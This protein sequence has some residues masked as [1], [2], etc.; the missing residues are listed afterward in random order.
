MLEE[1]IKR[2]IARV[3]RVRPEFQESVSWYLPHDNALAHY[4]GIISKF[5]AKQGIPVLSHP[6]YSPDLALADYFCFLN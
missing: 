3:H 2:L 1:M 5:L 6:P 4:S